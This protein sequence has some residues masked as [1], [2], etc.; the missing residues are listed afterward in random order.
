L[1]GQK[2]ELLIRSLSGN[3]GKLGI[4]R[5]RKNFDFLTDDE[6]AQLESSFQENWGESFD[7]PDDSLNR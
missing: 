7:A 3:K 5:R 2:L 1:P 6:V 4:D